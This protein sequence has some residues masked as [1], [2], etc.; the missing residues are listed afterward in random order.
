MTTIPAKLS[1]LL[2]IPDVA[3]HLKVDSRTIRRRIED[4]ELRAYRFGRLVRV[5]PEDLASFINTH[6][7]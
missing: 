1:P 3:K 5:S 7:M 4:G 2:T 6:R